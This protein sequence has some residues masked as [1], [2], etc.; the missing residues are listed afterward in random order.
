MAS[1]TLLAVALAFTAFLLAL[2][3]L[4]ATLAVFYFKETYKIEVILTRQPT[5]PTVDLTPEWPAGV[6]SPQWHPP[7]FSSRSSFAVGSSSS[8][9]SSSLHSPSSSSRRHTPSSSNS[10]APPLLPP[11]PPLTSRPSIVVNHITPLATAT[12]A[13]VDEQPHLLLLALL[14]SF[15]ISLLA[16]LALALI[17]PLTLRITIRHLEKEHHWA[18]NIAT[19]A[20]RPLPHINTPLLVIVANRD[21]NNPSQVYFEY[22]REH[23]D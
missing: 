2:I 1:T 18:Y 11:P 6:Q 17:V 9:S 10:T 16:I 13:V 14:G 3:I 19:T 15:L 23:Q 5:T 12:L 20:Q 7:L 21:N 22:I 8:S 4:I